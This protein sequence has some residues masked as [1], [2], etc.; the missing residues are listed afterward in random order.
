MM[1]IIAAM[2]VVTGLAV[3]GAKRLRWRLVN[4]GIIVGST[5]IGFGLGYAV[6]GGQTAMPLGFSVGAAGAMGCSI[7][8]QWRTKEF[9]D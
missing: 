4:L 9:K 8:N 3:A 7:W 5:C 1:L 2:V 6:V